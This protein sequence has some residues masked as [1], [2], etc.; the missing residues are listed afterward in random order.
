MNTQL[1]I[2]KR[3]ERHIKAGYRVFANHAAI[4]I[5]RWTKSAL[6]GKKYCYKI[7]YGVRS[8]R[9]VQFTPTLDYCNFDCIF[10][11][12][13]HT[14]E[15]FLSPIKFEE[16]KKLLDEAIKAQ[17][18]LL[19]GF[20]GNPQVEKKKWI[21]A[22][23]PKHVAI[24]LDGEPTLYPYLAEL[25]KEIKNRKM[26]AFLV[27]NGTFPEKLKELLEKDA[28]PTNLYISVY[29]WNLEIYKKTCN[30]FEKGN[31]YERVLRSLA[32][33]KEFEKRNCRTVL[34][35]TCVKGFNF[36]TNYP[37]EKEK[38]AEII[39]FAKPMF[40]EFK[41]YTWVGDSKIRLK[42]ENMP[43]IEELLEYARDIEKLTGYKIKLVDE[44]S[45]VVLLIRDEETWK[46]NIELLIKQDREI[47][48]TEEETQEVLKL[49]S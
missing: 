9:C 49:I 30:P 23:N 27:T 40:V 46:K 8:H 21:E 3:F 24:S 5:C 47:G 1:K 10:C 43:T 19:S 31:V 41:G 4:E 14:K 42:K 33:F 29:G 38:Y 35:F 6:K 25:I 26:T 18:E 37:E 28:I 16:P 20:G 7:W 36:M 2:E 13:I 48:Y 45:R 17:R 12:R 34:R 44:K 15:R 39:K 22:N 32:L 11:W